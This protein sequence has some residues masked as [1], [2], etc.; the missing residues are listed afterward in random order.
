MHK[1]LVFLFAVVLVASG[2]LTPEAEQKP[3]T[4]QTA[5]AEAKADL[6]AMVYV[7]RYKV[8]G[9]IYLRRFEFK[10]SVYC[11]EQEI[12][13]MDE[14]RYF[15]IKL[16]PGRHLFRSADKRSGGWL[17]VKPGETYYLRFDFIPHFPKVRR[18][19]GAV[20]PEQ[21]VYELKNLQYLGADKIRSTRV[22]LGD[23]GAPK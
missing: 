14:G 8:L 12:A 5:P 16:E 19:L 4:E 21:A 23:P 13:L 22:L 3:T 7:Y 10:P 1:Y 17:T 6:P 2:L 20:L 11:D 18:E 15:V 9:G